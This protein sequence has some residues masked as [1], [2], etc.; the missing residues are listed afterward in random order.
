[1]AEMDAYLTVEV[2]MRI[3]SV[4][5]RSAEILGFGTVG[6]ISISIVNEKHITWL[7]S[8][9]ISRFQDFRTAGLSP[10]ENWTTWS[11]EK[12]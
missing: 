1:M 9:S 3:Y 7:V 8:P 2:Y 5:R 10:K 4:N 12:A 6:L 11:G